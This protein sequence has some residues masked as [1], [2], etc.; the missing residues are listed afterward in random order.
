VGGTTPLKAKEMSVSTTTA[1]ENPPGTDGERAPKTKPPKKKAIRKP[2][3]EPKTTKQDQVLTQLK[4]G[5]TIPAIMQATG[6]QQHS[7]RGFFAGVVRKKLGLNLSSKK[8]GAG[9]V[10]RIGGGNRPKGSKATS[11]KPR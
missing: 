7:V 6:W 11:R 3:R 2:Q 10:Y 4:L 9:R 1:K 5:T 8:T